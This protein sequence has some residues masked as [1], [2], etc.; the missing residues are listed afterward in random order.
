MPYQP[1]YVIERV[2]E[3]TDG[4]PAGTHRTLVFFTPF[5]E[6]LPLDRQDPLRNLKLVDYRK[7]EPLIADVEAAEAVHKFNQDEYDKRKRSG[8]RAQRIMTGLTAGLTGM[9]GG[10]GADAL[11]QHENFGT[12][13]TVS[14][15]ALGAAVIGA[16]GGTGFHLVDPN[17]DPGNY[18]LHLEWEERGLAEL[19]TQVESGVDV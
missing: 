13:A 10:F 14:I 18:Y 17:L 6:K 11:A 2:Y 4:E 19:R 9:I 5:E 3:N 16:L 12:S 1:G 7:A 15:I 8:I